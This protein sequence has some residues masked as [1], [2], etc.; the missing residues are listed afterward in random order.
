MFCHLSSYGYYNVS[1][2][3]C[4]MS[5]DVTTRHASKEIIIDVSTMSENPIKFV[6]EAEMENITIQ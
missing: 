3:L 6:I 4:P 5:P 2:T 1:R